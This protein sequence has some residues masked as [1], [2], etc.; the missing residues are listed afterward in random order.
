[1]DHSMWTV[2]PVYLVAYRVWNSAA[3]MWDHSSIKCCS[4]LSCKGEKL[5]DIERIKYFIGKIKTHDLKPLHKLLYNRP[6]A[7]KTLKRNLRLFNGFAFEKNSDP[8]NKKVESLKRLTNA[9]LKKLCLA[10][11]LERNGKHDELIDRIMTFLLKPRTTG[12]PLPKSKKKKP[13]KGEKRGNKSRSPSKA[14]AKVTKKSE[15]IVMETSSEEDEEESK[16]QA[17]GKEAVRNVQEKEDD[18]EEESPKPQKKGQKRGKTESI[19]AVTAREKREAKGKKK[20]PSSDEVSEVSD[21]SSEDVSSD[22]EEEAPK[23]VAKKSPAAAKKRPA[24]AASVKKADSSSTKT[25]TTKTSKE[26]SE[27]SSDDEPLIKIVKK[28]PTDEQLKV[29]VKKLLDNANLEEVTMKQICKKVYE[30]YPDHDLSSRK[31]FIKTTV[32]ELIS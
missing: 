28:P 11:D 26:E 18:E 23:K 21:L 15:E 22:E 3:G 24:K 27:D 1:M 13:K 10:L 5:G 20:D 19:S 2:Q 4:R 32:K 30:S 8:Y 29:T 7:E 25:K 12:K 14:K 6:G 17:S 16:E 31:D 9:M